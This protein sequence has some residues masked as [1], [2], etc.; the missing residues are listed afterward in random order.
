MSPHPVYDLSAVVWIIL[1]AGMPFCGYPLLW[2]FLIAFFCCMVV[3]N[4]SGG[5]TP[6]QI[7][8]RISSRAQVSPSGFPCCEMSLAVVIFL[9]VAQVWQGCC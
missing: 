8:S 1:V 4:A 2:N 5:L 7:D 9:S 3:G 6:R